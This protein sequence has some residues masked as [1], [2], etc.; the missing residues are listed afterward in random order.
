[1][2]PPDIRLL[3]DELPG[4]S[5]VLDVGG[6][7]EPDPRADWVIDVGPYETRNWYRTLGAEIGGRPE[8]VRPETWVERDVCD[9]EP[10]PF[11]DDQ[12]DFVLCTQMLEDV[13]DPI[14]VCLEIARVGK[15]GYLETPSAATELTR[16]VESP[17]WC[18]WKH[19]RWLVWPDEGGVVFLAKPH[20]IHSPFWPSI[21]SPK[22]L[23]PDAAAPFSFRFEGRFEARE[24]IVIE[25]AALDELLASITR[26]SSIPDRAAAA[27]RSLA[28]GAWRVYRGLRTVVG[29]GVRALRS[30]DTA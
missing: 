25:Q 6:W 23:L 7:A 16:G 3:L 27:R 24:E 29:T 10:W 5:L 22:K 2:V 4:T 20:H 15:A 26:R 9:P 17:L 21:P 12:F 28:G 1:M 30:S 18:G 8:R 13:R 14:R 11:A 19:H